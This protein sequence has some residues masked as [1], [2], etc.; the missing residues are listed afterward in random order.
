MNDTEKPTEEIQAPA[1]DLFP[2][3][4]WVHRP[5]SLREEIDE[6]D[7]LCLECC[8]KL[9]AKYRV[10]FPMYAKEI[11]VDGGGDT[12]RDSDGF[13]TCAECGQPLSCY[14]LDSLLDDVSEWDIEDRC[15]GTPEKLRKAV[16]RL[17]SQEQLTTNQKN[18]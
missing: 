5:K 2:T 11:I 9:V 6:A 18:L 15:I 3:I 17:D 4:F 12:H 1:V 8:E 10:E 7:D 13:A 16:A 14:L